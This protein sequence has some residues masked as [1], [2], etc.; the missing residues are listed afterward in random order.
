MTSGSRGLRQRGSLS[1]TSVSA[2]FLPD[3]ALIRAMIAMTPRAIQSH[4][5][6]PLIPVSGLVAGACGLAGFL[7]ASSLFLPL[8][9][10]LAGGIL[11]RV[12]GLGGPAPPLALSSRD[13]A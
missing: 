1:S 13:G 5:A 4:G 11:R 7:P 6:A 9:S 10:L 3:S 2:R 8:F 12:S